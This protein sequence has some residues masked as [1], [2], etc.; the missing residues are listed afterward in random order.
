MEW[1]KR[2]LSALRGTQLS[3]GAVRCLTAV[4]NRTGAFFSWTYYDNTPDAVCSCSSHTQPIAA[5]RELPPIDTSLAKYAK[6]QT[7]IGAKDVQS[8][9][10]NF[11]QSELC[12]VSSSWSA[13]RL[14]GA[15]RATSTLE[16]TVKYENK[17]KESGT[18]LNK[19]QCLAE[20]S[21]PSECVRPRQPDLDY[22]RPVSWV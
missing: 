20:K 6:S 11:N 21:Y 9:L 3:C 12:D 7:Q 8:N 18:K 22:L 4:Q 14:Q 16:Q 17:H 15:A 19:V 5:V 10:H 2:V 1:F 13:I